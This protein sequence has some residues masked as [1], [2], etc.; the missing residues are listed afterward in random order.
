[1]SQKREDYISWDGRGNVIR[2]ALQG[3]EYT[4]GSLHCQ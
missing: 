2:N 1:M 4:G 3:P